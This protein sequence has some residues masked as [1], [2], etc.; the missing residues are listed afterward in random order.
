MHLAVLVADRD[1]F[2]RPEGMAAEAIAGFVVLVGAVVVIE[3][4][5]RMLVAAGLVHQLAE[6]LLV[7]P[8]APHAAMLPM[9]PPQARVDMA[10]GIKRRHELVATLRR[11]CRKFLRAREIEPDAFELVGQF[12]HD[13]I[14]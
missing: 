10:V 6:L 11:A 2:A 8:E 5:A 3:H 9:R 12:G 1:I 14:S 13:A 7:V 4:P